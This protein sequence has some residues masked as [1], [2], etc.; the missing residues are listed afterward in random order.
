MSD[1]APAPPAVEDPAET[2]RHFLRLIVPVLQNLAPMAEPDDPGDAGL[3]RRV[4][5]SYGQALVAIQDRI[6]RIARRD[7]E[8][9]PDA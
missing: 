2:D 9:G 1:E 7:I 5:F 3:V 8:G 4:N 6:A